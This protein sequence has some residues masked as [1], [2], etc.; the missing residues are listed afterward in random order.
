VDAPA[1][2]RG[3]ADV[4]DRLINSITDGFFML[5]MHPHVGRR[6]DHDLRPGLRS[7]PIGS[8]V[9][10]HRLEG[11]DVLILHVVHGRRDLKTLLDQ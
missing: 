4:A 3:D 2:E 5:S 1:S 7:L 10:I 8:Y 9:I 11:H 6:R